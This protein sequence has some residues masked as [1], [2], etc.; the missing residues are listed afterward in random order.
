MKKQALIFALILVVIQV[1]AQITTSEVKVEQT[2]N[3]TTISGPLEVKAPYDGTSQLIVNTTSS[4]GE[5]RF[6]N[7]G[8]A[9]GFVWYSPGNDV[10]AFGRGNWTNSLVV[11]NSGRFGLGTSNTG[12]YK[13][14]LHTNS[15]SYPSIK[16]TNDG[17]LNQ[18]VQ[19]GNT[20]T[21]TNDVEVWNWENGYFRVGTN[22][23]ERIRI[24]AN[25]NMGI[26][27]S[28]PNGKLEVKGP[29]SGDSQLI[30]N[31]TSSNGELRFSE[32]GISKGFV[33]YNSIGD[34]MA[35]GR[36]G[37]TN[38]MFVSN[39]GNFGIGLSN[40][41]AKLHVNGTIKAPAT[42]WSDF[43]FDEDYNLP[44]LQEV[45]SHIQTHGHLKDIPSEAEVM[46]SGVDLT[47]MDAKLLQKIEELTLYMI[48]MNKRMN[49]LET[50]NQEL[51][52][53]VKSL[54]NQ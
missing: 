23:T 3:Y 14:S 17:N 19:F 16:M 2:G 20:S 12:N 1:N 40:P 48:D 5:L 44:S 45:E 9:K 46:N 38:S 6:S 13:L 37:G 52:E 26:G 39:D 41:T 49:Q 50:E 28:S 21:N 4:N 51:K 53:K 24:D 25:G 43:V 10:M 22:N 31:T 15:S 47:K 33:W 42:D 54:E 29:Y 30:I 32:N 35:F 27:T 18:G 7:N 34:L 36:G 8:S 11:T